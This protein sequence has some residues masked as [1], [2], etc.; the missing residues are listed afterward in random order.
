MMSPLGFK[1]IN[2][3]LPGSMAANRFSHL[4]FKLRLGVWLWDLIPVTLESLCLTAKRPPQTGNHLVSL[5]GLSQNITI[6]SGLGSTNQLDIFND[7]LALK[8]CKKYH[9]KRFSFSRPFCKKRH[10]LM[11][12]PSDVGIQKGWTF[13]CIM[14]LKYW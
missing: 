5:H 14:T 12:A 1:V 6:S 8:K 10:I 13:I 9:P 4:L 7:A 3:V 11:R 2:A